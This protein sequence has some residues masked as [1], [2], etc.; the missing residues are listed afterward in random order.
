MHIG[1]AFTCGREATRKGGET[2]GMFRPGTMY[3]KLFQGSA[4][5]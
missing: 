2:D 3:L 4:G 1:T 5:D